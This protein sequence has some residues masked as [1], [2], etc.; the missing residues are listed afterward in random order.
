[1]PSYH[2]YLVSVEL[3][4]PSGEHTPLSRSCPGCSKCVDCKQKESPVYTF[5]DTMKPGTFNKIS[6]EPVTVNSEETRT[7]DTNEKEFKRGDRCFYKSNEGLLRHAIITKV[8]HSVTPISYE[9]KI[10]EYF[11]ET[12]AEKLFRKIPDDDE[13]SDGGVLQEDPLHEIQSNPVIEPNEG[14]WRQTNNELSRQSQYFFN[15]SAEHDTDS[16]ELSSEGAGRSRGARAETVNDAGVF[17][18]HPVIRDPIRFQN[19]RRKL[20]SEP[21]KQGKQV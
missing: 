17:W 7:T 12:N 21:R 19:R 14:P 16:G 10:L 11:T 18:S 8:D 4:P 13:V 9:V 5:Y 6:Q 15:G 1:M 3:H 2:A 20:S